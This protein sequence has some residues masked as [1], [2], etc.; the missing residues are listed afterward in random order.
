MKSFLK[1]I[2]R[3]FLIRIFKLIDIDID[4]AIARKKHKTDFTFV[5]RNTLESFYHN[6]N[7]MARYKKSLKLS[8]M[9]GTDQFLKQCRFYRLQQML[10]STLDKGIIGSVA[11]CG[12]WKGHSTYI[13]AEILSDYNFEGKFNIFDSFEMGLS[14]KHQKDLNTRHKLSSDDI[15]NE[16]K[17]FSSHEDD[18]H[19]VLKPFNF[20]KLYKGW[21]PEKFNEVK[22]EEFIFVHLD[23]DLYQ[24]TL[25]SLEFFY[26][27]LKKGGVILLDDYGYTQF[28]GA[29]K[30]VDEFLSRNKCELFFSGSTGGCFILK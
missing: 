24:P 17:L 9:E 28:P 14:D 8:G 22:D 18:L 12:C 7:N 15:Q 26:P 6:D 27:R 3:L 4:I 20:Y 23:V 10:K 29:K 30:C 5:D 1:K 13:I 11:E 2:I 25:D 19:K 16:K 21:I